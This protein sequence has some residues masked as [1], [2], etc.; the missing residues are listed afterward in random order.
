MASVQSKMISPPVPAFAGR[1]GMVQRHG[2]G[3]AFAVEVGPLGLASG[4]GRPLPDAVRGKM[5]A[6]LGANFAD[7]RVHVGPE[8]ERIGAIAFTVGSDLYFAPGRSAGAHSAAHLSAVA[9]SAP[10]FSRA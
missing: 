8:A 3:G 7:A 5:E 6:A 4:G 10:S 9:A 1:Q 2:A